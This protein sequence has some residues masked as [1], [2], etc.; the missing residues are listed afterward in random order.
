MKYLKEY[1]L[2]E[3][4]VSIDKWEDLKDLIQMEN[5]TFSQLKQA[6]LRTKQGNPVLPSVGGRARGFKP[7]VFPTYNTFAY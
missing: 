1:K 3:S 2:F 4:W 7:L 6:G 5:I